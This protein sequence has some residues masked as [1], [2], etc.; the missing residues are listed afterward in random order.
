MRELRPPSYNQTVEEA[1]SFQ[2]KAK[3]KTKQRQTKGGRGEWGEIGR[4]W[5]LE[6]LVSGGMGLNQKEIKIKIKSKEKKTKP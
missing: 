2:R 3:K 4:L 1:S 6:V 5:T